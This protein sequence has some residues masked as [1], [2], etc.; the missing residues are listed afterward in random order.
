LP[1][2][3]ENLFENIGIGF[4]KLISVSVFLECLSL[5]TCCTL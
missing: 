1:N 5:L 4:K 3:G 2:I